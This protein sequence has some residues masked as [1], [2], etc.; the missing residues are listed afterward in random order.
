MYHTIIK[1]SHMYIYLVFNLRS[2]SDVVFYHIIRVKDFD[3]SWLE[4]IFRKISGNLRVRV[5]D[6]AR[7][8][9]NFWKFEGQG[10]DPEKMC[11]IGIGVK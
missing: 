10:P 6:P 9:Q 5:C 2:V 7:I 8:V 11:Y 3:L 4:E 1:L